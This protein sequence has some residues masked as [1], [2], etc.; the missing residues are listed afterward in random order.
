MKNPFFI[1]LIFIFNG[2]M[3]TQFECDTSF[4]PG[5]E[6][7]LKNKNSEF[8]AMDVT[9]ILFEK[10]H[11]DTLSVNYFFNDQGEGMLLSGAYERAGRYSLIISSELY[12]TYFDSNI[13]VLHGKCHVKTVSLN[14]VLD[15]K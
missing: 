6:I 4:L 3:E 8:I 9:A 1:A 11:L 14:I 7:T 13:I 12:Q 10:N 5:V 15:Y 2:C